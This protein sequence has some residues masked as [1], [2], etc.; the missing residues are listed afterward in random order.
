MNERE[1]FIWLQGFMSGSVTKSSI[2]KKKLRQIKEQMEKVT[3]FLTYTNIFNGDPNTVFIPTIF[4]PSPN[5]INPFTITPQDPM[6]VEITCND[7]V[8]NDGHEV[9]CNGQ[10]A[11]Y[12]LTIPSILTVQEPLVQRHNIPGRRIDKTIKL[13]LSG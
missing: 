13:G 5:N 4:G 3:P 6:K 10:N 11:E 12:L 7:N 1:F 2:G 8:F 9:T